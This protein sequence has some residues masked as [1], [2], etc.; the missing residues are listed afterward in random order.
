MLIKAAPSGAA[1]FYVKA[2]YKRADAGLVVVFQ[3][4]HLIVVC[5]VLAFLEVQYIH[6]IGK[7]ALQHRAPIASYLF[8]SAIILI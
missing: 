4:A 8:E 1:S 7:G 3:A 5:R 6:I 2:F